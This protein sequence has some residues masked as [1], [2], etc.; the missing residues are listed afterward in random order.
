ML[1]FALG[2]KKGKWQITIDCP[3]NQVYYFQLAKALADGLYAP[4]SG[5]H[6]YKGYQIFLLKTFIFSRTTDAE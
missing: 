6:E 5:D 3:I 1:F 2:I 4:W